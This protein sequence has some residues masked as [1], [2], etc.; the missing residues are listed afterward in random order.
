MAKTLVLKNR[1]RSLLGQ[2]DVLTE[3]DTLAY[4]ATSE[5]S[6][7]GT[8]WRL[9]QADRELLILRRP[10]FSFMSVWHVSGAAGDMRIERKLSMRRHYTVSGG[11]YDGTVISGNLWDRSFVIDG[12][13]GMLA[14]AS[15]ALMSLRDRH[16][17][18]ILDE[19]AELLCVAA[20][21]A[22]KA[23]RNSEAAAAQ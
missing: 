14:R 22:I 23:D 11:P 4:R 10:W 15:I 3:D 20:M 19:E 8:R 17:V 6:W 1:L 9:C 2:I 5:L 16:Q 7:S 18:E 12:P 13:D 21:V